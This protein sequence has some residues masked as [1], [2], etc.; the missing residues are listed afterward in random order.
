MYHIS[1][2]SKTDQPLFMAQVLNHNF[3]LRKH[4]HKR[5]YLPQQ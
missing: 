4:N 2:G 5:S 3:V 1:L